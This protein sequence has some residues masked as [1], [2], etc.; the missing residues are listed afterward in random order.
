MKKEKK[1]FL[2]LLLGLSFVF[3]VR[4]QPLTLQQYRQRVLNYNQ[5]IRQS[6]EAVNAA[7]Y[8]LKSIKTGF[9]P[10]I[11]ITGSYSYQIE[12]VEF[13]EGVDLK[14][15]NY[16]AEA[17]L[18]QN[19]YAGSAVRRRYE[20]ARIEEAIARLGVEYT[21]DNVLYAADVN[22]WTVAANRDLRDIARRFVNIVEELLGVVSKRFEE[23]A[24]SKTDVLMVQSRLKEAEVQLNTRT[25]DYRT[26]VQAL[27]VMMGLEADAGTRLSD[28]LQALHELPVRSGLSEALS[29][30]PDYRISLQDIELARLQTRLVKAGYLPALSVGIQEKWGTTLINVDGDKRF[31]TIAFAN[32]NIPVFYWGERRQNVRL[33]EVEEQT[34]ELERSKVA[35][36]VRLELSN[37]WVNLTEALR[38]ITIV[39]SSLE[40]ARDNLTLNTFSYNEGKLPIIDV[41]SAQVTWLQA[42]TNVVSAHYQY[43]VALAEY[44]RTLSAY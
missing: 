13:M 22:Y 32:L 20:S 17:G 36:R 44:E 26:A 31:S 37:A 10:R 30:R 29:R 3:Y 19:V 4:A 21:V 41:L 18:V 39:S 8:S 34:R 38:K 9:F 43:K 7:V 23:G 15:D 42:Y 33:S 11:D 5:E 6:Q 27:N 28:S 1:S 24:I 16:S 2:L 14:H 40:I 12:R 25:T 35:D